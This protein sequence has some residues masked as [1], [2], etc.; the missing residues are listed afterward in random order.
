V[1]KR[2][3]PKVR[4]GSNLAALVVEQKQGVDLKYKEEKFKADI[5]PR[6]GFDLSKIGSHYEHRRRLRR[7][8][9]VL[10]YGEYIPLM[11]KRNDKDFE[12]RVFSFARYSLQETAIIAINLNDFETQFYIDYS[13]LQN[14]YKQTYS[15]NTVVMVTDWLKPDNPAQYY[16]LKE[17]LS[18]RQHIRLRPYTSNVIGLTICATDGDQF[19]VKKALMSSLERTKT[20]ITSGQSIESEQISLIYTDILE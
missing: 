9:M 17:L 19:V 14:I 15:P 20:K 6:A 1:E 16:F 3:L 7:E 5:N 13:P 10:R 18:M 2:G 11:A 8:K 12:E 4:S